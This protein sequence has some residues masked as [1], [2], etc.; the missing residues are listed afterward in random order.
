MS[1]VQTVPNL[2]GVYFSKDMGDGTSVSLIRLP[3]PDDK[4]SALAIRFRM[5]AGKKMLTCFLEDSEGNCFVDEMSNGMIDYLEDKTAIEEYES[6]EAGEQLILRQ[7]KKAKAVKSTGP[8]DEEKA[9]EDSKKAAAEAL[10][11][12]EADAS[13]EFATDGGDGD[14]E[15]SKGNE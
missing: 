5:G 12:D 13:E 4:V 3:R 15:D 2:K 6:E 1:D 14:D 9:I 10:A 8:T 11:Q 7:E